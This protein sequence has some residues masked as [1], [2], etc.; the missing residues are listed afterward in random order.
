MQLRRPDQLESRGYAPRLLRLQMVGASRKSGTHKLAL[1]GTLSTEAPNVIS[2]SCK[3]RRI[4]F[5]GTRSTAGPA[6]GTVRTELLVRGRRRSLAPKPMPRS[7][8]SKQPHRPQP[9]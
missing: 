1:T 5:P 8:L 3:D 4:A 2:T 9:H 6:D 7:R